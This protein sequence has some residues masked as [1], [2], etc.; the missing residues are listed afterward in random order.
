M[1]RQGIHNHRLRPISKDLFGRQRK[2][3]VLNLLNR[4]HLA[5]TSADDTGRSLS[6]DR[7]NIV[8][9][10]GLYIV[11]SID[12]RAAMPQVVNRSRSDVG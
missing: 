4:I 3:L 1:P 11:H 8:I 6:L 7:E 5:N 2:F 10:R 9:Q 12:N